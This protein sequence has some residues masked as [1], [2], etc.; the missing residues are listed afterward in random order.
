MIDKYQTNAKTQMLSAFY[1]DLAIF[2][3][4]NL[5]TNKS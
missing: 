2:Y 4:Q 5:V 3:R 1:A